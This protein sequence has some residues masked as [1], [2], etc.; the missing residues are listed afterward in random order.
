MAEA[1]IGALGWVQEGAAG[2][3]PTTE[4]MTQTLMLMTTPGQQGAPGA[5]HQGGAQGLEGLAGTLHD[6]LSSWPQEGFADAV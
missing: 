6:F 2:L 1:S 5:L 4:G 3:E